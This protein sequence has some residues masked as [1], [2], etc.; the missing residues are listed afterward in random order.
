M[1][2]DGVG[3]GDWTVDRV[4]GGGILKVDCSG[5]KMT[6]EGRDKKV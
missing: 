1:S 6:V 4:S 3:E 5:G 2:F